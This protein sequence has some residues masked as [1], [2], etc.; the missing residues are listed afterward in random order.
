[1]L[2]SQPSVEALVS[3]QEQLIVISGRDFSFVVSISSSSS[4]FP[5]SP[6]RGEQPHFL[7]AVSPA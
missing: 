3:G 7:C 6:D 1:M 2:C 5:L 4:V